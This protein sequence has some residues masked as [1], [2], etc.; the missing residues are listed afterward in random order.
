MFQRKSGG[1]GECGNLI[2][3]FFMRFKSPANY[4][5]SKFGRK[6]VDFFMKTTRKE[7]L[8]S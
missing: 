8:D 5:T 1:M 4:L 2:E 6:C 3:K 7:F